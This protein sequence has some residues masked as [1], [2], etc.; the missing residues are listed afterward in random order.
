MLALSH[1]NIRTANLS[2]MVAW[3]GAVLGLKAGARPAFSFNGA[4]LYLG[5]QPVI[6]LVETDKT[7]PP[8]S[9]TQLEHVSFTA[10]DYPAFIER[11]H[12][13]DVSYREV[14]VDDDVAQIVQVHI[15]D[16]DNNHLH[17]DFPL[18]SR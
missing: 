13:H 15:S 17:I 18:S 4:W 7:D 16:P 5:E 9:S 8:I 3:Y 12:H 11:L 2:Q 1:V 14:T 6:H 10:G